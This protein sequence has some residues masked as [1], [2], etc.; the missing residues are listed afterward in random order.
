MMVGLGVESDQ[1]DMEWGEGL[2]HCSGDS[3]DGVRYGCSFF[4][5]R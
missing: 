5:W 1:S 3:G 2:D 4:M